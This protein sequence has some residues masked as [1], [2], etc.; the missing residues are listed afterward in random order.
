MNPK[1][2]YNF[3]NPKFAELREPMRDV[4]RMYQNAN[5]WFDTTQEYVYI[6]QGMIYL[7]EIKINI[8]IH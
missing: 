2:I 5:R 8:I 4:I 3:D 7:S 1:E 6:K